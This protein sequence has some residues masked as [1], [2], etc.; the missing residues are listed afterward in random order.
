M[1]VSTKWKLAR[2]ALTTIY[3]MVGWVLFTGTIA[4]SSLLTGGAF[5]VVIALL[6][7]SLFIEEHEA[8][9]R[10][11]LPRIHWLLVFILVMVYKMYIASFEVLLNVI[12]GNINPRIVHFR[13]SL[14]SDVARVI[15]ANAITLTPGTMTL[16]IDDDHLVVHW[17]DAKTLHSKY[18]GELIKGDLETLLKRV[19]I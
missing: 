5:S 18:A 4:L 6:T 13:T 9:R 15:L 10:S 3:L 16:N 12:R 2:I 8:H 7:Y 14:T 11:L 1:H 19:F 17:L